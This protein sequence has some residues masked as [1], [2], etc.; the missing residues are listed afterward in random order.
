MKKYTKVVK[1]FLA[2]VTP[3]IATSILTT[4]PSQ[5]ATFAS[6]ESQFNINN[7]SSSPV[8][9]VRTFTDNKTTAIS[10]G[11]QVTA[12]AKAEAEFNIYANNS[13]S[14]LSFSQAQGQ[15]DGYTGSAESFAAIIGYDFIVDK[16][17]S[18]D[19]SGLFNL[20]TSIDDALTERANARGEFL[21]KLLDSDSGE[22]LDSFKISGNLSTIGNNDAFVFEP[23]SSITFDSKTSN[24][25][26]GGTQ[27]YALTSF[28]GKYSRTFDK[29][30]RLTLIE[31]KSNQVSVYTIPEPSTI[32]GSLFSCTMFGAVSIRKRKRASSA[33]LLVNK[34]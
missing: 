4:L 3:A 5:A 13:A 24:Q 11:G 8:D 26:F 17:F 7:F 33:A 29:L 9:V 19:F 16:E 23:S 12:D 27:E 10:T 28:K 6:S 25:Y 31:S 14:N 20:K 34:I 2:L 30:T 15:G 32:L 18:F 21:Y 22:V 1:R